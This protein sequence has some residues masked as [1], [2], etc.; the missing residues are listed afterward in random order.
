MS[1]TGYDT[2]HD[3]YC[4]KNTSVLKNRAGLR[5][6]AALDGFELEMTTLRALEPMP[7]G[8]FGPAHYK[9]VHHHLFQDIY[10]WAGR[11]RK[12][13][14]SKGGNAFC[15]PEHIERSME[16]LFR[17]L[18]ADPFL[19][20]STFEEFVTAAADFL[21]ELNAIHAFREGNGRAQ[22]SFVH[23]VAERA[24]HPLAL[25]RVRRDS[26][27]P[28]MIASFHGELEPLQVELA[29]MRSV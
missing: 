25:E 20:G 17:R 3:S 29:A 12:V 24:G 9:A 1:A 28:A 21:A 13:R 18:H 4:Y 15:Y 27:M 8:R 11:I 26:F 23:L 5:D 7:R 2:A 16:T 6:Q 14:T 22:L 10:S 19:G